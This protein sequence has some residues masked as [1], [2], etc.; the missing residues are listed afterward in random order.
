[1]NKTTLIPLSLVTSFLAGLSV[2]LFGPAALGADELVMLGE[3]LLFLFI[4]IVSVDVGAGLSRRV[5]S[6]MGRDA[7][8]LS[9]ATVLGSVA[10]GLMLSSLLGLDAKLTLSSSMGM[11]WY[12]LTGPLVAASLG[13]MAGATAFLSSFLRELFTFIAYPTAARFAGARNAVVL[14]GA[15]T[16]DTTLAMIA[17]CAGPEVASVSFLHGLIISVITPFAVSFV[18]SLPI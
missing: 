1:L 14:G 13:P 18:L 15:T 11:G 4:F 5:I 8:V 7:L 17:A 9:L 3:W 2:S 12:S 10:A 6:S 16:M